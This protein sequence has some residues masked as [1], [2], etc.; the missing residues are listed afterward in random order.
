MQTNGGEE[1]IIALVHNLYG[2]AAN[3]LRPT[4]GHQ[5]LKSIKLAIRKGAVRL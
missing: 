2:I 3:D 4:N 1:K 5:T